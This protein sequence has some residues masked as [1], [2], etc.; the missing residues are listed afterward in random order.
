VELLQQKKTVR[1]ILR[2]RYFFMA[3]TRAK[4]L[5]KKKGSAC[6]AA[7]PQPLFH[8]QVLYPFFAFPNQEQSFASGPLWGKKG[9]VPY[10]CSATKA[11]INK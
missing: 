9:K 4:S 8:R 2:T 10:L 3:K 7:G 11:E 6:A 1:I 5:K